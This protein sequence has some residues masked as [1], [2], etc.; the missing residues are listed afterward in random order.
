METQW[1]ERVD[2]SQRTIGQGIVRRVPA[3]AWGDR[4]LEDLS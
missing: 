2:L 3:D 1:S 4:G